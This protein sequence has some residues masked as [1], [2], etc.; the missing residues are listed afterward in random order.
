MVDY[1]IS[2]ESRI[3]IFM[4]PLICHFCEHDVLIPYSTYSNVE[5]PGILVF[6]QGYTA[7]CM[8][9]GCVTEFGDPSRPTKDGSDYLWALDQFLISPPKQ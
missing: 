3:T 9:C 1:L 7:T 8:L 2:K 6:Y 4:R 5:D